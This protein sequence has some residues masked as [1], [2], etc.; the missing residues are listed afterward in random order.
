LTDHKRAAEELLAGNAMFNSANPEVSAMS[1]VAH[2]LLAV[3]DRLDEL[4]FMSTVP[5]WEEG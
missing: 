1:A 2:A 3:C 4:A 5:L